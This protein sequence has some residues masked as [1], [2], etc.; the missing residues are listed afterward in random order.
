MRRQ[1]RGSSMTEIL[2][3]GGLLAMGLL[4]LFG[5]WVKLARDTGGVTARARA[6]RTVRESLDRYTALGTARL[7]ELTQADGSLADPAAEARALLD[8]A[9]PRPGRFA[10]ALRLE[11][12]PVAG[13]A[14]PVHG[15]L[16]RDG[17]LLRL[18]VASDEYPGMKMERLLELPIEP[19]APAWR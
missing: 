14:A 17:E 6:L 18:T 9:A 1:R 12:A 3:A 10:T 7:V 15:S 4:P 2:V 16:V 8:E 11:R 19:A 13:R 5:Y